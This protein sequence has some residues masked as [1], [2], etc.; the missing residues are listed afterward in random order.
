[1][2]VVRGEEG[3][4]EAEAE[5][6]AAKIN[7]LLL[8]I[9]LQVEQVS[10]T[11][12][13]MAIHHLLAGEEVEEEVGEED[14]KIATQAMMHPAD[15]HRLLLLLHILLLLVPQVP[16]YSMAKR[17]PTRIPSPNRTAFALRNNSWI[18]AKTLK[19]PSWNSLPI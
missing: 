3:V 4:E 11:S 12:M 8:I 18:Y 16:G 15:H 10:P 14:A 5:E 1:M 19:P 17:A 2:A 7:Q 9:L 13:A 6:E